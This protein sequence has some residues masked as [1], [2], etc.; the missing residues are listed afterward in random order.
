MTLSE[1]ESIAALRDP[2]LRNLR[3]THCYAELSNSF[4]AY[5]PNAANWCTYATWASR[6]AGRSIRAEDLARALERRLRATQPEIVTREIARQVLR[7][8]GIR[9]SSEAVARGNL[10]VF[11]EIAPAFARFLENADAPQSF[12]EEQKLLAEAFENY[13]RAKAS[14]AV[15][16]Q[17]QLLANLQIGLHEQRRL[18]PDIQEALDE[19]AIPPDLIENEAYG[20]LTAQL[21]WTTRLWSWLSPLQERVLR[22]AAH[23]LATETARAIR[24]IATEHLMTLEFPGPRTIRLG[25]DLTQSFP[26]SLTQ[27]TEAAL[28]TLLSEIDPTPNATLDSG[29]HDWAS[30]PDR[31]HFITDLFRCGHEDATL[32]TPPYTAAQIEALRQGRLPPPPL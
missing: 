30:F 27:I 24:A 17:L 21:S 26:A 6:Q 4:A 16:A 14:P 3:I 12:S 11:A 19:A 7:L 32:L 23:A 20:I 29:A 5:L 31:M 8:P 10:K 13:R 1:I 15:S 18:Q 28:A 2:V 9:R 25:S 22:T